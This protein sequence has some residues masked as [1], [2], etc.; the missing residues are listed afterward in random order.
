MS[1][2]ALD[3]ATTTGWAY[4]AAG[5]K[6]QHGTFTCPATEDDLGT[7]GLSYANWLRAKIRE[8]QPKELVFE[9]PILPAPRFDKQLRRWVVDTQI[10]TLRKLYGLSMV[11]E[12][13]AATEA[14]PSQE[15][16]IGKWRRLFLGDYYPRSAS[17]DELKRAAI[18]AC[19][20]MGWEPRCADDAEALGIWFVVTRTRDP[21]FAA[22]EALQQMMGAVP[23]V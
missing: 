20:Q 16:P 6:P 5:E 21:R 17:R 15:I 10:M 14:V 1:I 8:L 9:E 23:G 19:R 11:T 3:I 13:V 12:V 18:A 2:L 7:F 22:N 4:G